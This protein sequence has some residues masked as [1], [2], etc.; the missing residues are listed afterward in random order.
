MSFLELH[1]KVRIDQRALPG[2]YEVEFKAYADDGVFYPYYFDIMLEDVTTDFDVAM[3][4]VNEQGVSIALSN[5]GKNNAKSI[6]L[7]FDNQEDF[8]I[9]GASSQI[10]GNLNEGD[11]TIVSIL[12]NPKDQESNELNVKLQIDYTD[13]IGNRRYVLK[14]IPVIM[15]QQTKKGFNDL[16]AFVVYGANGNNAENGSNFFAYLSLVF[17]VA[18]VGILIYFKKKKNKDDEE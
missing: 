8:E 18:I 10:I 11:Y 9:L 3:Q 2:N 17:A 4:N 1:Y 12:L 6:T 13:I 15:N 14:T 7:R 16:T 5:I